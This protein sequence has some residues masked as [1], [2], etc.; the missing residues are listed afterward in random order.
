MKGATAEPDVNTIRLPKRT[1]QRMI[2]RSQ[3]FFLS[4]INDHS[5]RINS[6]IF[7]SA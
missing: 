5:S 3:N 4:F 2:G 7:A 6:L 1:R